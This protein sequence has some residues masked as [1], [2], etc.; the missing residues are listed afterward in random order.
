MAYVNCNL[1][2]AD[3]FTVVFPRGH[4]QLHRIVR[5]NRCSL[6]Y[7]NPQELIDC[8]VYAEQEDLP[9]ESDPGFRQYLQ[10]QFV[11]LPDNLRALAKLNDFAK[12]RG[13]L[14]EIGS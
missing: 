7:A 4:A 11:Q 3:D 6:M 2:G 9:P 14:F 13:K 8:D 5:C 10:K 12:T 1:C